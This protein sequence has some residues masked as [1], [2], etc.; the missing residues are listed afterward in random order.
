M[1]DY[2]LKGYGRP[3]RQLPCPRVLEVGEAIVTRSGIRSEPIAPPA[4]VVRKED[5]EP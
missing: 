2:A 4:E 1:G 3:M 5:D